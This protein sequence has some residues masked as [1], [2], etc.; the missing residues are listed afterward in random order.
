MKAVE[1]LRSA[2]SNA[3]DEARSL[4][5]PRV[6]QPPSRSDLG[7]G[8]MT[9]SQLSEAARNSISEA[10]AQFKHTTGRPW[11]AIS[12]IARR[13]SNQRVFVTRRNSNAD[14]NR[15][16]RG[17]L[18][19]GL[20]CEE[21]L[22]SWSKSDQLLNEEVI[23][24]HPLLEAIDNPNHLM[25]RSQLFENTVGSLHVT[26]RSFWVPIRKEDGSVGIFPVPPTWMKP[27]HSDERVFDSWEMK[28][29][30]T[31]GEPLPLP[32][33]M[34]AMFYF[35]DWA[36][37]LGATSPVQ[38]LA[39]TILSDE[40]IVTAQHSG[41]N[42]GIDPTVALIAGDVMNE[43]GIGV[44]SNLSTSRPIALSADQ[45][46]QFMT[47]VKQEYQGARRHGLPTDGRS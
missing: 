34:V 6:K 42:N 29:P 41:F 26:G 30:N 22:P 7:L 39:R 25:V 12:I 3:H 23:E 4:A 32:R 37:P 35:S 40:A 9:G 45:R 20:L 8:G 46:R 2:L 10:K 33:D 19:K 16:V 36:N 44:E 43:T 27:V 14:A 24:E 17:Y 13:I 5:T 47:W 31:T 21:N 18:H 15:T 1:E 38:M 28:P 11:N